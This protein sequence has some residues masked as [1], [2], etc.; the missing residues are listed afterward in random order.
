M[1][2]LWDQVTTN[3][4]L[5]PLGAYIAQDTQKKTVKEQKKVIEEIKKTPPPAA[6]EIPGDSTGASTAA[7]YG[8]P[9]PKSKTMMY[10]IIGVSALALTAVI[11]YAVKHKKG[12]RRK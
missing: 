11:I 1:S 9:E 4:F 2:W 5:N 12:G 7:K 10:V 6:A 3:P 8:L